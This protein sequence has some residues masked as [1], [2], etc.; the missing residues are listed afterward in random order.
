MKQ[1][2]I[3]LYVLLLLVWG[4]VAAEPASQITLRQPILL[5][6]DGA[7]GLGLLGSRQSRLSLTGIAGPEPDE[8]GNPVSFTVKLNLNIGRSRI[9]LR[10]LLK[11]SD[12]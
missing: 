5:S 4:S 10:P 6:R 12:R 7:R 8:R 9:A 1:K 2:K 3:A 11:L